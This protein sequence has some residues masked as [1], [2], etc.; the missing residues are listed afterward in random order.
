M[1]KPYYA[2]DS[3]ILYCG[4][5]AKVLPELGL[6]FDCIVTDPPY[7]E[8]SLRWDRWPDGWPTVV[9]ELSA[10]MWCFGSLRMFMEQRQQFGPWKYSQDIVWEKHN[11]S[12]FHADRFK[13]VHEQ[14]TFW[15]QGPWSGIR[16][17][18]PTTADATA[19][20]LRRKQRPT[21]MGSI[22]VSSPRFDG[23]SQT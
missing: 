18:T 2:D 22:D 20:Q 11:G 7:E 23:A 8:T 5:M 9:A 16:H 12:G 6:T 3:V 14:A 15:Y 21:H 13:R 4:D 17:E 10:A 19:R 1:M